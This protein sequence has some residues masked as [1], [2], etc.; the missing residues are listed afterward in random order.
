MLI[1]FIKTKSQKYLTS[2][3]K[4]NHNL[5][6]TFAFPNYQTHGYLVANEQFQD[7]GPIGSKT[8]IIDHFVTFKDLLKSIQPYGGPG[9]ERVNVDKVAFILRF[10]VI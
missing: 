4:T 8:L 3:P 6:L 9:Q 1:F 7:P 2:P 5:Q 10:K